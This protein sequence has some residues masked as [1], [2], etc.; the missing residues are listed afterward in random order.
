MHYSP[1]FAGQLVGEMSESA[2]LNIFRDLEDTVNNGFHE[3]YTDGSKILE[4]EPSA[5]ASIVV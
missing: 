4:P 3:V 2:V 5:A 1:F